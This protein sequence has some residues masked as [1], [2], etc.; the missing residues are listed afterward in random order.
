MHNKICKFPSE[1][2]YSGILK[3]DDSILKRPLVEALRDFW[4]AGIHSPIVFCDVAEEESITREVHSRCNIGEA[5]KVV[6]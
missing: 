5:R 1:H 4:P 3:A 2:F 6:S